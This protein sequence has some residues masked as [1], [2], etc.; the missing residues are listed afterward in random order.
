MDTWW[1]IRWSSLP[2]VVT[3]KERKLS[4][5]VH[6]T[7]IACT[8]GLG[9]IGYLGRVGRLRWWAK[10]CWPHALESMT[11]WAHPS[12]NILPSA[13][14]MVTEVHA[15]RSHK[16]TCSRVGMKT[17]SEFF[18]IL[19]IDFEIF[20][21]DSSV[22]V[23]FENGIGFRNFLSESVSESAWCFTDRFLRLPFFVGNYRICV[24]EFSGIVSRNFSEFSSM[25]FF[26]SPVCL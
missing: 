8:C 24:S 26:A 16:S 10:R 5:R 11:Q 14:W 19:K 17:V 9:E 18:G 22:T 1:W 13:W 12:V 25:W 2:R 3:M 6:R 21:S 4:K 15:N 20:R 7:V 23:F